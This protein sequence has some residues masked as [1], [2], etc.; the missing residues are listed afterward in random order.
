MTDNFSHQSNSDTTTNHADALKSSV[1][2][3]HGQNPTEQ[4]GSH[5]NQPNN[6][7]NHQSNNKPKWL[8]YLIRAIVTLLVAMV[9]MFVILFYAMGT[10]SGTKF[11]LEKI[12]LE[13]GTSLKYS[14]GNLRQGVWVSDIVIAHGEDMQIQIDRAYVQLG[15][16][17]VLARQVH[18]VNSQIDT[19]QVVNKQPPTDEPFDYAT[20]DLPVALKLE[21]TQVKH[22]VYHQATKEPIYLHDIRINDGL[23]TGTKIKLNG[24]TIRYDDSVTVSNID[25]QIELT[26]DYP[27]NVSAD[28]EVQAIKNA[29]FGVLNTHATGTLKRTVGTLTSK[30]HGYDIQGEFIA[31]GLD[32]NSPFSAKIGFDKVVLPYATEQSITLTDGVITADGVISDIELRINTDLSAKDIPSG[33]YR[34]RGV[35]RD[36]GMAIPFLRADTPSGALTAKADMSWKDEFELHA[37]L[38]GNNYKIREIIPSEYQDYQAY[39]PKTLTGDLSID[40]FYLDEDGKTRFDFDL[41]Q[42]DGEQIQVSLSQSQDIPNAPWRIHAD[43]QNLIRQDVPNLGNIRSPQGMADIRLEKGRVFI[44]VQGRINELSVA[45]MGDYTVKARIDGGERIHLS[46]FVYD[47]AMGN[48]SGAGYVELASTQ[49]PL[50]WQ[51]DAKTTE[52]LPNAYFDEPNKTPLQSIVGTLKASGRMRQDSKR[53]GLSI[54]DVNIEQSD[55]T[56]KLNDGQM[57]AIAGLGR[58]SVRVSDG[59]LS[60]FDALFDGKV[61]QSFVPSMT[62]TTLNTHISGNLKAIDIHKLHASSNAGQVKLSGKVGFDDGVSWDVLADLDE[63]DTHHFNQEN[64]NAV[65][66]GRLNSTGHY[67]NEQLSNVAVRFDGE[68]G[69]DKLPKGRFNIDVA[70]EGQKYHINRLAYHG[71]AGEFDAKGYLDI[72]HGY[73]WDMMANMNHFDLGA[74]FKEVPSDLT[75]SVAV[76]GDWQE[77]QQTIYVD[78]LDLVGMVRNQPFD[79]KGSLSAELSLPKDLKAYFGQLKTQTPKNIDEILALRGQI[80]SRA[81]MAQNIIKRLD[82]NQLDVRWGENGIRLDGDKSNLTTTISITDLSQ[83]LPDVQGA[84][85]GGIILMDDGNSLPTLYIDVSAGGVRTANVVIQEARALGRIINLGSA[86]SQLLIDV[87]DIIAM[88]RVVKS[89]RLDFYGQEQNHTLA[90]S[91]QSAQNQVNAK[92]EGSLD[93]ASGRYRGVLSNGALHSKFGILTQKQPTEFSYGIN[94]KSISVAAHCWQSM[95]HNHEQQGSLCLQDTLHYTQT[96][97][98]VNLV[99]QNLNTSVFSAVLPSDIHWQSV[100]S[101]KIQADWQQGDKPSVNAV[102]YSDNGRVGLDQ[103]GAYVEMPYER[104]SVIAQSVADG[105]KLRADVAGVVARGY[106]DVI[107]DP[108]GENKPISGALLINDINLAVL[109]PFFPNI[110]RLS[111]IANIGGGLGG[112]LTQPLF[113]GNAHLSDANLALVGVPLSLSSINANMQVRGTNAQLLG[114]FM[115]GS[116]KGE[117]KGELDWSKTLQAHMRVRGENL[118]LNQPP[119]LTAKATPDIEIIARPSERYVQIQGVVSVPSAIIRPPESTASIVSESS[120]VTVLDRRAT[121]D[122]E[123]VLAVVE[124]WDINAD[125]G[126]DLGDDVVFRGLGA[127]LPLAGALHLTQSG[128]GRM[129]AKGVIQV[130]ERTKIDGI[131]QNLELNYAQVRFNGDVLN[132][133]LS[134]EGEKQIE[135]Q[136][137][138]VRVKGTISS[139]EITVFND[140]GLTEQQAMNALVTGRITESADSQISEQG[141]RSKVTNSLAAAGLSLGL[142]GTRNITNQIGQAFGLE[143]LTI[144]ASGSSNDTI[145]SVTGHLSP[146]LYIRYGVG[147]FNAESELSMR[148]QLTR[149]IYIE[150]VSAA[151]NTVDVIYR[152]KF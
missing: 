56:A 55:L 113:Y 87:K 98:S 108:Y 105:L 103:D 25:G 77:H 127:K 130:S 102:L 81:K 44:D 24:A 149:R 119:L 136:T 137:V 116:G 6:G 90:I 42:K 107:V 139:P 79:A 54:H 106:A 39:L 35:V 27:L 34:G 147:L 36:G 30:Y 65:I 20:I 80:D 96:A 143:S 83:I 144:D 14:E 66:T 95:G 67:N 146:D 23:W 3:S 7:S 121:G 11:L 141:F 99:V 109:R 76:R 60:H 32:E 59:E 129:R 125:I 18:L 72:T 71:V 47:G 45:P 70:G 43:W 110:Q 17:A 100:L 145:V 57:V 82:A 135:G 51:I 148:Y 74:F 58:A 68:V 10:Q 53:K 97:G 91:T 4:L 94:D 40:Y 63:L 151:Q 126:L 33:R 15:F 118:E 101:G 49:K 75:G 89:A 120:D 19:L 50:S 128:Q 41:N 115:A 29:Y 62:Q 117:L 37:T 8:I 92:I 122:I 1:Q 150:A 22:I 86:D 78:K 140:A 9:L 52:L 26:G 61:N 93:R 111:G 38:T 16:R 31:Q 69:H 21:N 2:N 134:I 133:R 123:Q 46:N 88:G 142:T 112:T 28:V 12:A 124:P 138:G 85:K 5:P 64:L 84:I 73:S 132:P 13:T 114:E 48:L 104:V 152:W 131:G